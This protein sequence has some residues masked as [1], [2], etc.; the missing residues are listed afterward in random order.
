MISLHRLAFILISYVVS[1]YMMSVNHKCQL[2]SLIWM[3][4]R[5]TPDS[6]FTY[7]IPLNISLTSFTMATTV[8]ARARVY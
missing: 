5:T 3:I 8:F 4:C 6:D 1:Q 7:G 2:T